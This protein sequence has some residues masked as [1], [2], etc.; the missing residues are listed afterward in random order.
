[1][2]FVYE[3][4]VKTELFK[5]KNGFVIL[6]NVPIGVCDKCGCRYYSARVLHE[7]D[8]IASGR[9]LAEEEVVP[10]AEYV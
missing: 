6:K 4:V 3:R 8:E 10:I 2:A 1:M 5:H 7:V 9:R